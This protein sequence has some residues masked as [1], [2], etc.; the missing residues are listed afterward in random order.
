MF[1]NNT[2]TKLIAPPKRI[3]NS[4]GSS[5]TKK[6]VKRAKRGT[7][8]IKE[9]VFSLPSFPEAMKKM[10]VATLCPSTAR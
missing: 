1:I 7:R 8:N 9:L 5:K 3:C 6:A 4:T 2:A 10:V